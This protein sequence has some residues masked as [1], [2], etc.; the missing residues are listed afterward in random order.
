MEAY[1]PPTETGASIE[2]YNRIILTQRTSRSM[3]SFKYRKAFKKS[4]P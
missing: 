3:L 2:E 4:D 1:G